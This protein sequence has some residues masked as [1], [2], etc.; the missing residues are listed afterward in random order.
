MLFSV[1]ITGNFN[2]LFELVQY[3]SSY[4]AYYLVSLR[5]RYFTTPGRTCNSKR[6]KQR[7]L[8]QQ[9]N[10]NSHLRTSQYAGIK[11]QL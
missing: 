11:R 2:T 10:F 3:S 8:L 5:S 9:A 4:L 7:W 6:C 1:Y